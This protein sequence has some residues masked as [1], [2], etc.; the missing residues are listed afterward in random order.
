MLRISSFILILCSL[1]ACGGGGG[2]SSSST[3]TPSTPTP[4]TP[5]PTTALSFPS[6]VANNA[7]YYRWTQVSPKASGAWNRLAI[8]PKNSNILYA[9]IESSG[10]ETSVLSKSSDGGKN[11]VRSDVGIQAYTTGGYGR[12]LTIKR[13]SDVMVH[14]T[15][16]N[17]VYAASFGHGIYVSNDAGNSWQSY[18]DGLSNNAYDGYSLQALY[19][20][21]QDP[22]RLFA[23]DHSNLVFSTNRGKIWQ[24]LPVPEMISAPTG[25]AFEGDHPNIL[26]LTSYSDGLV[27]L[28][29]TDDTGK[30]WQTSTVKVNNQ[31]LSDTGYMTHVFGITLQN[32]K[33]LLLLG[34][35]QGLFTSS[36]QGSTWQAPRA[37]NPEAQ[38][39]VAIAA[40]GANAY[41]STANAG[42]LF[43]LQI[44]SSWLQRNTGL[45][46]M[47]LDYLKINPQQPS[48]VYASSKSQ[49]I[50]F[51][52][53]NAGETWEWIPVDKSA[54]PVLTGSQ[55]SHVLYANNQRMP[56]YSTDYGDTW[57]FLNR[58][59]LA[60]DT[61]ISTMAVA[62]D[63]IYIYTNKAGHI[64]TSANK[65]DT[66]AAPSKLVLSVYPNYSA[67]AYYFA[68][69]PYDSKQAYLSVVDYLF[70]SEDGGNTW[71]KQE[72]GLTHSDSQQVLYP[73]IAKVVFSPLNT[74][75]LLTKVFSGDFVGLQT[76]LFMRTAQTWQ[77]I[78]P[79]LNDAY[80]VFVGG[81]QG[82]VLYVLS[83]KM[84][85]S[86]EVF[87]LL[88]A[89]DLL[90]ST[91]Q[92][93]TW[94]ST[95]LTQTVAM[96]GTPSDYSPL[97]RVAADP[98]DANH[99]YAV[100][101]T[102]YASQTV[103]STQILHSVDAGQTWT[104]ISLLNEPITSQSDKVYTL[105]AV[106]VAHP[107]DGTVG[108]VLYINTNTGGYRLDLPF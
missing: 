66:W 18:S 59:F 30:T 81:V 58:D 73:S 70:K 5:V 45:P 77:R 79:S 84:S 6:S 103:F 106:T 95:G 100:F 60:Y 38:P 19:L 44:N 41:I 24:V 12:S 7:H 40:E 107:S 54:N 10:G 51:Q 25:F 42:Q 74:S 82:E 90:K 55:F 62:Q 98:K 61:D 47:S 49:N 1:T 34:T 46:S 17:I 39:V 68:V 99:L 67:S 89:V 32:G 26:Y 96:Y 88:V 50:A 102:Q 92:G 104:P 57:T 87:P 108:T 48:V 86:V 21:P 83:A 3:P 101:V 36:D 37:N 23:L 8:D 75:Y 15:D 63:R 2:D 11:W 27:K 65:G 91:D 43:Q 85:N 33:P 94:Q 52:S 35:S 80:D 56:F 72:E 64:Y 78:A 20:H 28:H 14:P 76:A 9:A 31:A 4:S 22:E 13:I 97:L 71:F 29:R 93:Q 16:S 69:S 105:A 53:N